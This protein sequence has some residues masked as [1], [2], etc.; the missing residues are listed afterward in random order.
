MNSKFA[1]LVAAFES[2]SK[3]IEASTAEHRSIMEITPAWNSPALDKADLALTAAALGE[4]VRERAPDEFEG[5]DQTLVDV[6][7]LRLKA[8]E[9]N[10]VPYLFNGNG[11]VAVP[12]LLTSLQGMRAWIESQWPTREKIDPNS[13]PFKLARQARAAKAR[14]DETIVDVDQ[15]KAQIA[16][17]ADAHQAAELLP[18]DLEDLKAARARLGAANE[19][20]I[21]DGRAIANTL[22][23]ISKVL[24]AAREASAEADG[25][26]RKSSEAYRFTTS[27]GLAASFDERARSLARSMWVWVGGLL[28]ALL[29]VALIGH[30]RVAA[31]TAIVSAADPQ[32]GTVAINLALSIVSVGAP[33][34]FAWVATK[35]IGQRFRLSEDYGFKA[36]VAKAYEGYRREAISIDK[37]FEAQLFSIALDRLREAPLRLVE[38]QSHGSPWHELLESPAFIQARGA[39]PDLA[40][41]VTEYVKSLSKP[42]ATNA[43]PKASSID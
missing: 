38:E 43:P 14:L 17:I 36:S 10:T 33:L 21:A 25:Y 34:W 30:N 13:L 31:L 28:A 12:T 42:N 26:A 18:A 22:D 7:V 6:Y 29:G 32:W 23:E 4:L 20:A 5:D 39:V 27:H 1:P 3:A 9:T 40:H 2:L 41:R 37:A 8:L 11:S 15:I 24:D 35:Q 16:I 19:Q